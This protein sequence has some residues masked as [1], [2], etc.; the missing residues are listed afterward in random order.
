MAVTHLV[1][2][3]TCD[4]EDLAFGLIAMDDVRAQMGA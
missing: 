2:D 4:D 3:I 1:P